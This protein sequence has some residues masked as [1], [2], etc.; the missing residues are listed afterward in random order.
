[1]SHPFQISRK[2][3]SDWVSPSYKHAWSH[4][5]C[6]QGSHER[7]CKIILLRVSHSHLLSTPITISHC[8]LCIICII[9]SA[10][11]S[12]PWDAGLLFYGCFLGLTL[13]SRQNFK[14][15]TMCLT[16]FLVYIFIIWGPRPINYLDIGSESAF[17]KPCQHCSREK[18]SRLRWRVW[19]VLLRH[20]LD[21]MQIYICSGQN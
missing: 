19:P 6:R 10:D 8:P 18:K 11:K 2:D 14:Y 3:L 4:C 13:D 16:F 12:Q 21:A 7:T 17:T 15:N 1:M 20:I 9:C 5:L